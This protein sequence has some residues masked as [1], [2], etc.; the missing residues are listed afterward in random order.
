MEASPTKAT[1]PGGPPDAKGWGVSRWNIVEPCY[2]RQP[3]SF[4]SADGGGN[5][6][7]GK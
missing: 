7:A 6:D 3:A 2:V 1:G 5:G 4:A